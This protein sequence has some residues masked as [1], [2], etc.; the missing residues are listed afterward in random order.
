MRPPGLSRLTSF[1]NA[2]ARSD[3]ATCIQTALSR[4]TSNAK[5][6]LTVCRRTGNESASHRIAGSAWR[7]RAIVRMRGDGS[8]ATTS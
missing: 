4:I 2:R 5:P 8:T 7:S 6:V 3:G 1:R